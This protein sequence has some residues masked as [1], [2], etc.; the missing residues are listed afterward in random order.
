MMTGD[1]QEVKARPQTLRPGK[2]G[3]ALESTQNTRERWHKSKVGTCMWMF[4][5]KVS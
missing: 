1:G 4:G 5:N 2:V 3:G